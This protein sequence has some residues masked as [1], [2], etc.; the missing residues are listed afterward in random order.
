MVAGLAKMPNIK[1]LSSDDEI[2]EVDLEVA[3]MSITLKVL[4]Q[5]AVRYRVN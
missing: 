3:R 4:L 5:I 1:L 2:F